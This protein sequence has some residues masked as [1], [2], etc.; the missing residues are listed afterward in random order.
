M[1]MSWAAVSQT[2]RRQQQARLV[3]CLPMAGSD[4]DRA[5]PGGPLK[6]SSPQVAN[7]IQRINRATSDLSLSHH[8]V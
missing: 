1:R 4:E 2:S 3:L 8:R 6:G 5:L 7:A